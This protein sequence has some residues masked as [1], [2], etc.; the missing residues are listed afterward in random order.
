[1]NDTL[2]PR[3]HRPLSEI[4]ADMEAL[5]AERAAAIEEM[6]AHRAENKTRAYTI[7]DVLER[8]R[9]FARE[10]PDAGLWFESTRTEGS[11]GT[12]A[13]KPVTSVHSWRGRYNCPAV[14]GSWSGDEPFELPKAITAIESLTIDTFHGYKGGD[15]QYDD[16]DVLYLD[17]Y[18]DYSGENVI[19]GV[20]TFETPA[21][22][23]G[24]LLVALNTDS[25]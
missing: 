24:V 5:R 2:L 12:L 19:V 17:D 14:G 22:D 4:A 11:P 25:A 21:G 8:L 3:T 23:P 10:F 16:S 20:I 9:H 6:N 18:G 7:T 13:P 15:Y 1:M